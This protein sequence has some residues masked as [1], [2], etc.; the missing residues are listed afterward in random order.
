MTS[1][2]DSRHEFS[3]FVAASHKPFIDLPVSP[4]VRFGACNLPDATITETKVDVGVWIAKPTPSLRLC[5]WSGGNYATSKSLKPPPVRSSDCL[6]HIPSYGGTVECTFVESDPDTREASRNGI[7]V[8]PTAQKH[9]GC[10]AR[11]LTAISFG[12]PGP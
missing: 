2:H 8:Q 6:H 7:R 3:P 12:E 10:H 5:R 1:G 9:L 4:N 11:A